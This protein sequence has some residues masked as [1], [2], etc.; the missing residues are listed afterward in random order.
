MVRYVHIQNY[1]CLREVKVKLE[2]FTVLVGANAS[3]KRS[4]LAALCGRFTTADFWSRDSRLTARTA[5]SEDEQLAK[6]RGWTSVLGSGGTSSLGSPQP[7]VQLLQLDTE[8]LRKP[9]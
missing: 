4:F 2:P 7:T 9:S 6:P 5:M 8:Q 3:G 1:R